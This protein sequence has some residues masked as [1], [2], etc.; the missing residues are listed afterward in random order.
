MKARVESGDEKFYARYKFANASAFYKLFGRLSALGLL[1]AGGE[2]ALWPNPQSR[3]ELPADV[4]T[5]LRRAFDPPSS[6]NV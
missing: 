4:L 6:P 3:V 1:T 5:V 2:L